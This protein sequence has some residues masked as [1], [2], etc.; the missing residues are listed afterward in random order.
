MRRAIA[1]VVLLLCGST[2]AAAVPAH[3]HTEVH[4]LKRADD[5]RITYYLTRPN[6]TSRAAIV[7]SLQGSECETVDPRSAW[8]DRLTLP[9]LEDVM[10]LDIEKYGLEG[11]HRRGSNEEACPAEY[12][13]HNTIHAD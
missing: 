2:L 3:E 5:S 8:S 13:A 7:L 4:A 9:G 1:Y 12:L 6:E 10:R 11:N